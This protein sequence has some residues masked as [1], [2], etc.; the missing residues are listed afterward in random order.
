V[1]RAAIVGRRQLRVAVGLG[2]LDGLADGEGVGVG[3]LEKADGEGERVAVVPGLD[4]H[5]I[6]IHATRQTI[7]AFPIEFQSCLTLR[8]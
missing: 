6:A 2:E 3:V 7:N 8:R 4:P 5:A 1:R